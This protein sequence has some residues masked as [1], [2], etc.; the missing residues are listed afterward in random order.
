MRF[1]KVYY[2]IASLS[3]ASLISAP[4]FAGQGGFSAVGDTLP[5]T[6]NF[7]SSQ[8]SGAPVLSLTTSSGLAAPVN[9]SARALFPGSVEVAGVET[10][11]NSSGTA[12]IT[13]KND[14]TSNFTGDVTLGPNSSPAVT[15]SAGTGSITASGNISSGTTGYVKVGAA[16]DSA[17]GGGANAG[18]IRWTGVEF[19]GCN[20]TAWTALGGTSTA[21]APTCNCVHTTYGPNHYETPVAPTTTCGATGVDNFGNFSWLCTPGGWVILEGPNVSNY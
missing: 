17:C 4:A 18:A 2:V 13:L 5:F 6:A 15:I 19:Q 9:S 7:D 20:G 11:Y 12:A 10:I 1:V 3:V 8:D 21:A 16:P 14:G